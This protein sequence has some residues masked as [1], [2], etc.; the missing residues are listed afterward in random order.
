VGAVPGGGGGD[1]GGGGG[2]RVVRATSVGVPRIGTPSVAPD[3]RSMRAN[4]VCVGPP[5]DICS[6]V[7][8]IATNEYVAGFPGSRASAARKHRK[9]AKP[10]PVIL[11]RKLVTLHGGQ[12][13]LV[14]IRLN[15]TGRRLLARARGGKLTAYFTATQASAVRGKPGKRV[16]QAKV[17]FKLPPRRR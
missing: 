12:R 1:T 6:L 7:Y 8:L 10:K 4:Q 9:P 2:G 3:G 13:K 14:T 11:G 16:K 5:R 15:A 17:T